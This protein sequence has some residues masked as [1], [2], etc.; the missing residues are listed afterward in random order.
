[1]AKERLIKTPLPFQGNL[2]QP[3]L[4]FF[5]K[6]LHLMQGNVQGKSEVKRRA[7]LPSEEGLASGI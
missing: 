5:Q 3:I 1:M 2:Q 4:S 7:V 6:G